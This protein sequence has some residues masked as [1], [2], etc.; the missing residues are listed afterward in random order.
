MTIRDLL[1]KVSEITK[2]KDY[3]IYDLDIALEE[4][5]NEYKH[6]EETFIEYDQN[7]NDNYRAIKKEEQIEE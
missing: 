2:T 3:T 5:Y 4:L 1:K 6:L 7:I